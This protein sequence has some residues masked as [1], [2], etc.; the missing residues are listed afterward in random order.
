MIFGVLHAQWVW[1]VP[2]WSFLTLMVNSLYLLI[3]WNRKI[4]CSRWTFSI[5]QNVRCLLGN[6]VKQFEEDEMIFLAEIEMT[7][8]AMLLML[9]LYA[10]DEISD[11]D[12]AS[13]HILTRKHHFCLPFPLVPFIPFSFSPF[14][15]LFHKLNERISIG[16]FP[17]S[18]VT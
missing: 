13:Y 9:S 1:R 16:T 4:G 17:Y 3:N 14:V 6:Y 18:I 10:R 11:L 7:V 2:Y 12:W 15:T 8:I 5:A